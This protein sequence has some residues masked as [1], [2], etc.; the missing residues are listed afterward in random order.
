MLADVVDALRCP[1]CDG[2]VHLNGS[3]RCANGH[4]FDVARQGYVNL[5]TGTAPATADTKDMVAARAEFLAAGHYDEIVNAVAQTAAELV[6]TAPTPLVVDAGAG[7]GYWLAAVLDRMSGGRGLAL[8]S[9]KYA[10]RRAARAHR[11]IGAAVCDTWHRLPVAS[12]VA[13]LVLNVFAPRNGDEFARVLRPDGALIVVTPTSDHLGELVAGCG[14]LAVDDRK[15]ARLERSLA[16][17]FTLIGRRAVTTPLRLAP[18]DI[19]RLVRMGPSA[20]HVTEAELEGRLPAPAAVS[21]TAAVTI[22]TYHPS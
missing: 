17:H 1:A 3:L 15:D 18:D 8:D 16:E 7:T 20:W 11:R 4:S 12:G 19:R 10:A 6:S 14:L 9:S 2:Q 13:S 21:A 5:Q 22:S